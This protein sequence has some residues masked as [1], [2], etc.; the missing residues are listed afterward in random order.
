M[1]G[2][3]REVGRKERQKQV[4]KQGWREGR[5]SKGSKKGGREDWS[6]LLGIS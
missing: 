2:M 3:E 4:S 6:Y 5:E 1:E